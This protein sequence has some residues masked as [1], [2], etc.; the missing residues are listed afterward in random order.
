LETFPYAVKTGD[1]LDVITVEVF[2]V[3]DKHV[4]IS[5]HD[6]E[7]REG[8]YYDEVEIR[9][10]KVGIYLYEKAGFEPLVKGGDWVNFF[11]S[12]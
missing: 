11:G 1:V 2:R 4:E 12:S 9:N 5:I 8:Y 7:M 3:V 10:E 6:L